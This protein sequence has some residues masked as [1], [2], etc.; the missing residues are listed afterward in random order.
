MPDKYLFDC[1]LSQAERA[2]LSKKSAIFP[3]RLNGWILE[4]TFDSLM[5]YYLHITSLPFFRLIYV[6]NLDA[7]I[8]NF[9]NHDSDDK[10]KTL[11]NRI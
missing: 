8:Y 3:V 2:K 5:T 1:I 11:T 9:D 7:S 6:T 10:N 4:E